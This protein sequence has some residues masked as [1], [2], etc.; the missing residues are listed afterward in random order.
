MDVFARYARLPY[1]TGN[2]RRYSSLGRY[3]EVWVNGEYKGLFCLT[4]RINRELLGGKAT[5]DGKTRC[6]IYNCKN[7]GSG[8][9]LNPYE[10]GPAD[11]NEQWNSWE[12]K[13]PDEPTVE[14]WQTLLNPYLPTSVNTVKSES[15]N[16][17]EACYDLQGRRLLSL[18]KYKD[19]Y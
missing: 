11:G 1:E 15:Q 13:Y 3:V 12:M 2:A 9:Y 4:D 19:I 10:E 14:A 6:V 16:D 18:T 17:H 7:Y 8:N 5:T